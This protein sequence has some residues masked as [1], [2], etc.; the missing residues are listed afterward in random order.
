MITVRV[1]GRQRIVSA[2]VAAILC[3]A[4]GHRHNPPIR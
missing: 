1:A 4:G 2:V 3:S